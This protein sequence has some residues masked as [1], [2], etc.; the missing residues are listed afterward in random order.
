MSTIAVE[1]STYNVRMEA[2]RREKL[3]YTREKQEV[4]GSMDHDDWG[5]VLPPPEK[6]AIIDAISGSGM[7]IKDCLLSDFEPESNHPSGGFFGPEAVGKNFRR[8]LEIHPVH[9]D[10]RSSLAG[11]YM[12]NFGSYREPRWNPDYGYDHLCAD[13]ERY[14]LIHGIGGSQHFC[15]DM[16]IGFDLGFG[17]LLDKIREY[18]SRNG[19]EA[20]SF[21]QGL[22]DVL[23]GMQSWISRNA[24]EARRLAEIEQDPELAHNVKVIAE[25]NT[26]LVSEPP[27]TFREA[28]QWTLWFLM[29]AR[30]YNGSGSLGRMDTML[31]PFYERDVADGILDDDEAVFHIACVLL[32]DTPYI[33]LGGPDATR[34]DTTNHL[35]YLILEAAHRLQIPANIGVSVGQ[36]IDAGL[37]R[38]GVEILVGDRLGIPKFLGSDRVVE[39]FTGN[40]YPREDA[41]ERVYSGCHWYAIPGR[42]YGQMDMIKINLGVVLDVALREMMAETEPGTD[43][44]WRRFE[45]HLRRAIDTIAAGIDLHHR[46]MRDVFPELVMDLLCTGPI[47]KGVDASAGALDYTCIGV[48]ASALATA[49][50]SFAAMKQRIEDEKRLSWDELMRYLDSDWAGSDGEAARLMMK[51]IRRFGSGDS[52]ADEY[53]VRVSDLFTRLTK[54]KPTPGGISMLPGIFSWANTVAMVKGLGATPNGRHAGRPISHGANPDPGF[55]LGGGAPTALAVAVAAVQ[56]GYGNTAPMQMDL[57]P[58]AATTESEIG[59]LC[60]LI[61]THFA[62]GGTQINMNVLDADTILDAYE[63]PEKYPDLVVRVTGFS[64]Y[65]SSL[66]PVFRKMVVDRL[67]QE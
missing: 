24:D 3:A 21:Y 54:E 13:H 38:R 39:G 59:N 2:L 41:C 7:P 43:E 18:R 45:R 10:P 26:R 34:A 49:A 67:L 40:G 12:T 23:I 22:E 1:R 48:D 20:Q 5:M 46:H 27:R 33:Q 58:Q 42:E 32:R 36:D 47:E 61:R 64:A 44:L 31:Y 8:L 30:M 37:L 29:A 35:S 28:C 6:R 25:I 16:Q 50:D 14:K 4:L 56:S 55:A 63:H 66:S 51:N 11:A 52:V 53:A 57:T 65:F 17:G 19:Q 60:N 15:Q 62:M 9:V